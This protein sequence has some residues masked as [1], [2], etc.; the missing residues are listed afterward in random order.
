MSN[1]AVLTI[2]AAPMA[3]AINTPAQTGLVT[4]T[5]ASDKKVVGRF[6]ATFNSAPHP[7]WHLNGTFTWTKG[8]PNK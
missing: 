1:L 2:V 6:T 8:Y 7:L 3:G 4:L 5:E